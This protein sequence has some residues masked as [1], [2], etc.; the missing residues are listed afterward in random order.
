MKK[1]RSLWR[2]LLPL[3]FLAVIFAGFRVYQ[4][5][6]PDYR[7]ETVVSG[8]TEDFLSA[9]GYLVREEYVL[10]DDQG[11]I[12]QLH[13]REGEKVGK[14]QAVA[15]VYQSEDAV[16]LQEELDA[17][18]TRE[19]QL[20]SAAVG[21]EN[22]GFA[23]RLDGEI[24]ESLQ[25]VHRLLAGDTVS[26]ES[27]AAMAKLR[28]LVLQRGFDVTGNAAGEL[29]SVGQQ[30]RAL[31]A[32]LSAGSRTVT[33][34]VSGIYSATTDGFENVLTP[35]LMESFKPSD[36]DGLQAGDAFSEVGK[37]ITS[38]V[39]YFMASFSEEDA[40]LLRSED[41]E[42][43]LRFPGKETEELPCSVSFVSTAEE[44]GR[45]TVIFRAD[46][47]LSDFSSDRRLSAEI[48]F[49]SYEGLR[50]SKKALRVNEEGVSGVYCLIG[51]TAR[52]K[53]VE[54]IRSDGESVLL[55]AAETDRETLRLR[56]RDTVILS[57]G[58][59]YDGMILEKEEG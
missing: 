28:S 57:S 48:I 45:R 29:E 19:K 53:P 24:M 13:F 55:R 56:E 2:F 43:T 31:K 21:A 36:L 37:L 15:T 30:I 14:G 42:V 40:A 11:G 41:S 44:D 6:L 50:V 39:W 33:A 27:A 59:L 8:T 52:F 9:S 18:L 17:L 34:P 1:R 51:R 49:K 5:V 10:P 35:A 25:S 47:R 22:S 32:R 46:R 16:A 23:L 3:V 26:S 54:V 58:T 20:S 12:K 38:S 7:T 4:A